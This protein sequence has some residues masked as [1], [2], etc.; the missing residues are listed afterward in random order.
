[1]LYHLLYP[2]KTVFSGFNLFRYITFRATYALITSLLISFLIG[3]SFIRFLKR[4][5]FG[6]KVKEDVPER[7][8][9]KEGTP[10]MGGLIIMIPAFISIFLWARL[11]NLYIYLFAISIFLF[12]G[13]GFIDDYLKIRRI[14]KKGLK[15]RVKFLGE[16]IV[17]LIV[18][19]IY[20]F[21]I[22]NEHKSEI[23]VPFIYHSILD[24]GAFYIIFGLLILLGSSNAVNL[25][26]GLDGLAIGCSLLTIS[27]FTL[28]AYLSGH[29]KIANYLKIPYIVGSGELTVLGGAFIGASIGF[30]WYNTHPA[31]VFM[32][33]TGALGLGGLI[34]LFAIVLKKEVL[35][36][37]I[38][39]IFV[40]EAFSVI[41]Q[42]LSFR[43]TGKRVFKMAPLHHHFELLGYP[44]SKIVARFLIVSLIFTLIGLSIELK[45]R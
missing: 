19:I 8:R 21:L 26:D 24:L 35:L 37:I 42:V 22:K 14:K 41:I 1:M 3:K 32:G 5:G 6:E 29:I 4:M 17:S 38:G 2:L 15:I 27:A 36:P 16:I 43:L 44:E 9:S 33:D 25:T 30:L 10:S 34:G 11:D 45:I 40:I 23:Y 20:W 31:E 7:H 28:L 13:L 18:L 39:G 12:S